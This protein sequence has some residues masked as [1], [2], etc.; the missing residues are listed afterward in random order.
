MET[1]LLSSSDA[2][3]ATTIPPATGSSKINV[4]TAERIASVFAG[5][6]LAV[7][8]VRNWNKTSGKLLGLTS[9]ILL[10]RGST[11]YCEINN[12]LGRN[13]ALKKAD[14]MEAAATF[15][16]NK[17][18]EE[19]FAFWRNLS[20]LPAFMQHLKKVE[21][22][23]PQ[24]S[25]WT[26]KLPGGVATIS[27]EAVIQEEEPNHLI[28]WSSLPGSTIDNAGEVR[29]NDAPSNEG[30]VV[31]ARISYRLPGGDLG[32]VAGKL[33]NPLVEKMIK[34]DLRRFKSFLETGEVATGVSSENA[35]SNRLNHLVE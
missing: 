1:N 2:A 11:G 13:S 33:F 15:T 19:V 3:Q 21:V 16:I 32:S 30:T 25:R 8:A 26:A 24:R 18:K 23:D 9:L 4:G 5:T 28:A 35:A 31:R 10:K 14:A 12:A 34:Q 22:Q 17:P 27:W 7:Y 29:F 20:N 6:A